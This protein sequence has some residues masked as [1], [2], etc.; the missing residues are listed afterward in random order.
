[1]TESPH[2]SAYL[3]DEIDEVVQHSEGQ[4]VFG[5]FKWEENAIH[6]EKGCG[7]PQCRNEP[8]RASNSIAKE[9]DRINPHDHE[10]EYTEDD[11]V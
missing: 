4:Y 11:Y 1:M 3:E 9:L 7:C 8:G 6:R 10:D 5:L 2:M